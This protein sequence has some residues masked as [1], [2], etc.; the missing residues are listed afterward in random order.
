MSE[1]KS[2]FQVEE[3]PPLLKRK[4]FYI[5]LLAAVPI[6]IA[7]FFLKRTIQESMTAEEVGKSIQIVHQETQW[8]DKQA[9]P[10]EVTIV[11]SITFRIRNTGVRALKNVAFLGV[12]KFEEN[13]EVL[14]DGYVVAIKTP[15]P[16]GE[17]SEEITLRCANGYTAT[18]KK[19]FIDNMAS[20]KRMKVAVSAR[21][22]GSQ[23]ALLG[24][25]PIKQEIDG[26]KIVYGEEASPP[27]P[28]Q[29]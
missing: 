1:E 16:P 8:V 15:L 2:I 17:E 3:R 7:L 4:S 25:Y 10:R 5:F 18:S 21:V 27:P 9:R 20:W 11:P 23:Y 28:S 13:D 12:F 26:V 14:N 24:V 6:I 19:A 29:N 22:Y